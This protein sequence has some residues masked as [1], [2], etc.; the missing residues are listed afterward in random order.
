MRLCSLERLGVPTA[1]SP[2]SP[3]PPRRRRPLLLP[4][5]ASAPGPPVAAHQTPQLIRGGTLKQ[6]VAQ[7]LLHEYS[8]VLTLVKVPL[9]LRPA[10][11]AES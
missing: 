4:P 5:C 6:V 3:P 11:V 8:A 7:G 10:L 1:A 2:A 9:D